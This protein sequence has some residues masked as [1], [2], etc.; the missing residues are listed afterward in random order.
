LE[1]GKRLTLALHSMLESSEIENYVK[2]KFKEILNIKQSRA[3]EKAGSII[4]SILKRAN[5]P[6]P[7][8]SKMD[9]NE[10]MGL[11]G[12]ILC[13]IF[14]LNNNSGLSFYI[15]WQDT[16][17]SKSIGIDIVFEMDNTLIIIES[18]HCHKR[19]IGNSSF[20]NVIGTI[21]NDAF[22]YN[23]KYRIIMNLAR[24]YARFNQ[25]L[26]ILKATSQEFKEMKRKADLV[27]KEL[28]KNSY[29]LNVTV[30]TD[31]KILSTLNLSKT[32]EKI[33]ASQSNHLS[34]LHGTV[35]AVEKLESLSQNLLSEYG[36]PK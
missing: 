29:P 7:L 36:E 14:H 34:N 27:E 21:L 12:E 30:L 11:T 26:R 24:L 18:K 23:E 19:L 22:L 13:E 17:T 10:I 20:H 6:V 8:E 33:K 35:V 5:I 15:K 2:S 31:S 1:K 3:T 32:M 4:S 25:A 16:G 28:R 9:Y